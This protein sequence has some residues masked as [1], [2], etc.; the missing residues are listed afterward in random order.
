[1]DGQVK[2]VPHGRAQQC[3]GFP[4]AL[5]IMPYAK[6]LQHGDVEHSKSTSSA[7]GNTYLDRMLFVAPLGKL[8][9]IKPCFICWG[10][11]LFLI[12]PANSFL[13]SIRNS[14]KV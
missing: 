1:M 7:S 9:Q 6:C 4:Q 2:E 11:R 14:S 8:N 10:R 13:V 5:L 12:V 3:L